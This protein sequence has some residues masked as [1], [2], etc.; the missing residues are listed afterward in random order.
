MNL[1]LTTAK[2]EA[3]AEADDEVSALTTKLEESKEKSNSAKEGLEITTMD[4]EEIKAELARAKKGA[5]VVAGD[6]GGRGDTA[7]C[8]Q[9]PL[10]REN[11]SE[12]CMLVAF[13]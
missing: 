12:A 4:L 7:C 9:N 2:A 3:R 5:E 13:S 6:D 8:N 10:R 1:R 11:V